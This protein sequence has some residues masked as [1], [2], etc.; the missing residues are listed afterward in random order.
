MDG[1][2][3]RL[4]D[5]PLR[6][7]RS[8]LLF[9]GMALFVF[10]ASRGGLFGQGP[11]P[12]PSPE[13]SLSVPTP[14]ATNLP[15]PSP[16]NPLTPTAEP[17]E[18]PS[19]I[20]PTPQLAE[21]APPPTRLVIP[22]L[23]V[24][25]PVVELPITDNTWDMS[26][27]TYEIAHLGGTAKPGERNN[28]VLAGHVTLRRG[29]GPFLHLERLEPGN[30]AIVYAGDEAYTYRVVGKS[31]VAPADVSIVQPTSDP[32][33]TLLTCTNWEAQTRLYRERVAVIAELVEDETPSGP[34]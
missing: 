13:R 31:Y 9:L 20:E 27:L 23:G 5:L 6:E 22:V 12:V 29:A 24:D 1:L 28:M 33:L 16:T 19:I 7:I 18:T 34:R 2:L 17:T 11:S 10:A 3:R 30:T 25:A 14:S 32:I 4:R 26:G 8:A 15:T 21:P